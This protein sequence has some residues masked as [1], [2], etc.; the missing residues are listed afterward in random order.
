MHNIYNNTLSRMIWLTCILAFSTSVFPEDAAKEICLNFTVITQKTGH[1]SE[2]ELYNEQKNLILEQLSRTQTVFNSNIERNCPKLKFNKGEIKHVDWDKA[3]RLSKPL[4][5]L[6]TE[7]DSEFKKRKTREYSDEIKS[8][9]KKLKENP[10]IKYYEFL[11]LSPGQAIVYANRMLQQ[12]GNMNDIE[13]GLQDAIDEVTAKLNSDG[14]EEDGKALARAKAMIAKY[15]TIDRASADNWAKGILKLWN[16]VEAQDTSIEVKNLFAHYQSTDKECIDVFFV[17]KAKSPSSTKKE[18]DENGKWTI[19]GGAALSEKLFPRT[20]A[21]RGHGIILS[22]DARKTENRLAHEIGHLLIA[23]N[24]AH[25][26]KEAKDLMYENSSGGT[27]LDEEEC[28]MIK[29]NIVSF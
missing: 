22:Q 25:L 2:K 10:D 3:L 29:E 26:G 9:A 19:R 16:D 8:I 1:A 17:P 23:K 6:I 11:A 27:Y 21:G 18:V 15:E 20:T 14:A 13:I 28:N 5:Q 7:T 24:N 12:S 4:D